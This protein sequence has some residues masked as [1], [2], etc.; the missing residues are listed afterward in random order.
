MPSTDWTSADNKLPSTELID[1]NDRWWVLDASAHLLL[2]AFVSQVSFGE[3][4]TWGI[5]QTFGKMYVSLSAPTIFIYIGQYSS[6]KT[7]SSGATYMW[8]VE[9]WNISYKHEEV[10]ENAAVK[11]HQEELWIL[12]FSEFWVAVFN[13]FEFISLGR[14]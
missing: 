1:M 14:L 9:P 3:L 4:V 5:K 2:H 11:N 12:G 8:L 6:K 7:I 10:Q 13:V